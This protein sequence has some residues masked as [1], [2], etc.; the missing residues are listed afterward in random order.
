MENKEELY[1]EAE[2]ELL[3]KINTISKEFQDAYT[4]EKKQDNE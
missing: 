1:N 3:N 2:L 4:E